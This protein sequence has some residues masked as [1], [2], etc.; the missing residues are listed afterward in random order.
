[1]RLAIIALSAVI[2]SCSLAEIADYVRQVTYSARA[3]CPSG[4]S[5]LQW[6]IGEME[7]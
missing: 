2:G 1:M 6:E 4:A 7:L 5:L 3:E